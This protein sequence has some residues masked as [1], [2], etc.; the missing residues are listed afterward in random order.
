MLVFTSLPVIAKFNFQSD[1]YQIY[2][3]QELR[4]ED[5]LAGRKAPAP[6][7][8]TTGGLFGSTAAAPASSE[9]LFIYLHYWCLLYNYLFQPVVYSARQPLSRR[10]SSER[11]PQRVSRGFAWNDNDFAQLYLFWLLHLLVSVDWTCTLNTLT[12]S[13]SQHQ[14]SANPQPPLPSSA[15]QPL[16]RPPQAPPCSASQLVSGVYI[17]QLNCYTQI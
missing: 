7:T 4:V 13:L 8:T 1:L 2:Y 6:G 14:H 5:Y 12:I 9:C 16:H 3:F 10:A 15:H 11:P 17:C